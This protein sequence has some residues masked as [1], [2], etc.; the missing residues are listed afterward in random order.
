MAGAFSGISVTRQPL[1]NTKGDIHVRME[2]ETSL[3]AK[4]LVHTKVKPK[5]VIVKAEQ[6][7]NTHTDEDAFVSRESSSVGKFS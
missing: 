3:L 1:R 4:M 5:E 6:G 2:V 7:D